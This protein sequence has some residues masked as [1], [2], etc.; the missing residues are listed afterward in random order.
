MSREEGRLGRAIQELGLACRKQ[1]EAK[2]TSHGVP[3]SC[4]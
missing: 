1:R 4:M 2:D 3:G